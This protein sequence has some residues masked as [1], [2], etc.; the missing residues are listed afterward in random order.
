MRIVAGS[1]GGRTIAV[2]PRGTQPTS[3]RV[4]EALF[5]RLAAWGVLE[6]ARVLDLYA[7]SGAL[8][9]EA[10]SRGASAAVLVEADHRAARVCRE[11]V[12]VLGLPATVRHQKVETYLTEPPA[13]RADLV[14]LDPPYD[15]AE[16]ALALALERLQAHLAPDALVVVER[17]SR[18]PEPTLPDRLVL[19]QT[20]KYGETALHY[21]DHADGD[22]RD[23]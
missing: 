14:F 23:G 11:N 7:G 17:S 2:P 15:L 8:G 3:D 13:T 9:L 5:G 22:A 1:A 12:A 6:G 20:K 16:P 4:R 21:L 18:S 19:A 10:L